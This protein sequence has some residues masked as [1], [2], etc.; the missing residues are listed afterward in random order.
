[1]EKEFIVKNKIEEKDFK[2]FMYIST[3]FKSIKKLIITLIVFA[4]FIYLAVRNEPGDILANFFKFY[5]LIVLLFLVALVINLE[6][7]YRTRVR[8][9]KSGMFKENP[10]FTFTNEYVKIKNDELN[11]ESE[12]PYDY[13]YMLIE[14]KDYFY[15]YYNANQA[16]IMK[17]SLIN[18]YDDFRVFI[19]SKFKNNYRYI[20]A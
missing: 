4:A 16:S 14:T 15:F 13:F 18:D 1:M 9:D 20:N 7:R 2:N 12:I 11:S 10:E 8:T 17:K 5:I 19:H 6:M 3:F